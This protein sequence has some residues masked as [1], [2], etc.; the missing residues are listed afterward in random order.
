MAF[1][2]GQN[3][4]VKCDIQIPKNLKTFLEGDNGKIEIEKPLSDV[5]VHLDNGKVKILPKKGV[6]YHYDLNVD[7]GVVA[8]FSSSNDPRA[9]QIKMQ[10]SNGV[11]SRDTDD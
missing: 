1:D 8:E 9:V 5:E 2:F 6:A 7:R 10:I 3:A 4:N 11:I